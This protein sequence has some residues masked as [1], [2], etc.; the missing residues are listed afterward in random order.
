[1]LGPASFLVAS[2]G[3][4]MAVQCS[5][6]LSVLAKVPEIGPTI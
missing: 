5:P 1:M 6:V 2:K 3:F 4:S